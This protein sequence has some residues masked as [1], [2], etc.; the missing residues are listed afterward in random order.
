MR[1]S[2]N[3]FKSCKMTKAVVIG[4]D[5]HNTLGVIR[6]LGE[7]GISPD[8]LIVGDGENSFV[9]KSRYVKSFYKIKELHSLA[10]FLIR[11]YGNEQTKP[12]V[13][14][15]SDAI[16]AEIDLHYNELN[17]YFHLP[18]ALTQGKISE[19]MNKERMAELALS[20]GIIIPRTWYYVKGMDVLPSVQPPCIVK[21]LVSKD[22]SKS[23]IRV[24]FD[25]MKLNDY[26][27]SGTLN[28]A[29]IQRFVEKDI[30]Y[31]LIGCSTKS[32]VIIPGVSIILRPCKGSNTSF[33][34]YV[35][36]EEGFCDIDKCKEYVRN[37]GYY[38][39]F[40]LE[41]LRDKDGNDYF[42]E[43]NF[44][45]DG[46]AICV[47]AAGVSLPLIWY[48]DCIGEDYSFEMNKEIQSVYVMPDMAELK[49][50]FTRQISLK[51]YILDFRKTDRFM[52]YDSKD[53]KP[54]WQ[55][56]KAEI[57]RALRL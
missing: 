30:E 10:S 1:L 29:Q 36:L 51:D 7:R 40:S 35:P 27:L 24:F 47:T 44:R 9:S 54:F 21:P 8:L 18:G 31:Q 23:D 22:G 5:H 49:L 17:Q 41:F 26:L 11:V 13:F 19:L 14:C 52:E 39:L 53:P 34:R 38:G 2:M 6:G 45:N 20:L 16:E 56:V 55:L 12:V 50:L 25:E 32:G 57:R 33:L 42:M 37:T 3:I 28:K 48:L 43:M 46:N 15:C 4:T